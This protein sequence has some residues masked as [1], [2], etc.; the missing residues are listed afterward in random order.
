MLGRSRVNH[1]CPEV[2]ELDRLLRTDIRHH[3]GFSDQAGVGRVDAVYVRPKDHLG[4][5]QGGTQQSRR[6]VG[7]A[8]PE[9]GRR[10]AGFASDESLHDGHPTLFDE[11]KNVAGNQFSD[12]LEVRHGGAEVRV[13][14][15]DFSRV[16]DGRRN[17][18]GLESGN[19]QLD[20]QVFTDGHEL[21]PE[22]F[23]LSARA[24]AE[25][26][27]GPIED[28]I[29]TRR[30]GGACSLLLN[31]LLEGVQMPLLQRRQAR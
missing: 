30:Q 6:E 11:R 28:L 1:A 9:R 5:A 2:G 7:S 8:P 16:Q 21:I 10:P 18:F 3:P 15:N 20:R 25:K 13:R 4:G 29:D 14:P 19:G 12:G 17:T 24:L 22:A 23:S 27:G 31:D 26:L